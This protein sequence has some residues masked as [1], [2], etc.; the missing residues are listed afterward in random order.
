MRFAR[1]IL[2]F[3]P[4]LY[5]TL[6]LSILLFAFLRWYEFPGLGGREV[7]LYLETLFGVRIEYLR[8]QQ[9]KLAASNNETAEWMNHEVDR[10]YGE[11][12]DPPGNIFME[13]SNLFT[14][15]A[16]L[17]A[18]KLDQLK[19]RQKSLQHNRPFRAAAI[20]GILKDLGKDMMF[21]TNT[22][23]AIR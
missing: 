11:N 20:Q 13:Y 17:D 4:N 8:R 16:V 18:T 15:L 14:N 12:T 7:A 5:F 10:V 2:S 22:I 19:A 6:I 9:R 3:Q 21:N 1:D 23:E